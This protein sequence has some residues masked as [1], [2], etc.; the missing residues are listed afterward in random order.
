MLYSKHNIR[1][2]A[3]NY[4]SCR[5]YRLSRSNKFSFLL[6]SY[7]QDTPPGTRYTV[8]FSFTQWLIPSLTL[9]LFILC[10]HRKLIFGRTH[11]QKL[12]VIRGKG[13][14]SNSDGVQA[15]YLS[16]KLYSCHLDT[17]SDIT[18]K[19][20]DGNNPYSLPFSERDEGKSNK[21]CESISLVVNL[22]VVIIFIIF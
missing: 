8:E 22:H 5:T 15:K 13:S 16:L 3:I 17:S 7:W 18:Q 2:F 21:G 1:Q 9:P 20:R 11:F 19:V 4:S 14:R 12:L 6:L 10:H